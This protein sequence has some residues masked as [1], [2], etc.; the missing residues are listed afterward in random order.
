MR[1]SLKKYREYLIEVENVTF[2][3]TGHQFHSKAYQGLG[4][5]TVYSKPTKFFDMVEV[6]AI[7]LHCSLQIFGVS[8]TVIA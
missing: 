4:S 3:T 2:H 6:D 7:V 1:V 5:D 8:A